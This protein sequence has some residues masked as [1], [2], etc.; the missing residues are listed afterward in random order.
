MLLDK[1]KLY[2][3]IEDFSRDLK[4]LT[5]IWFKIVYYPKKNIFNFIDFEI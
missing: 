5:K 2:T 4:Q 3:K 1:E